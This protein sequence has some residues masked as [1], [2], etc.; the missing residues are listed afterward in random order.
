M[1]TRT[2]SFPGPPRFGERPFALGGFVVGLVVGW[3]PASF[4]QAAT[5]GRFMAD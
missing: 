2:F 4:A 5:L 1:N 3:W